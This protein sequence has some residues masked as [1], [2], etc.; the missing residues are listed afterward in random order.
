MLEVTNLSRSYGSFVAVSQVSF[1]IQNGEIVG[2]L[3]HN[4]AG[5]TTIMKMLSGFLEPDQGN[6]V[7]DG[8][9]LAQNSKQVQ[10]LLGYLPEN[11]PV[12]PEMSVAD[13]LDYAADLKGL[14]EDLKTAEVRRVVKA[15]ELAEKINAPIATLSRGFKQ[16]VGVAQALLGKPKVLILDEPTNGLDPTQTEHMRQLIRDIAKSATVILS[17]HIMQEVDA[18]CDR[19]LIV[20]AGKLVLDE[21]LASLKQSSQLELVTTLPYAELQKA[22]ADIAA[23]QAIVDLHE[24]RPGNPLDRRYRLEL[25]AGADSHTTAGLCARAVMTHGGELMALAP[26]IRNLETLFREVS[27]GVDPMFNHTTTRPVS[28]SKEASHAA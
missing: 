3:G 23:V 27:S 11:L 12:Y 26:V 15:T 25:K 24:T 9:N 4:G 18:L 7:F 2:L 13:Y 21:K 19:V 16:R 1:T 10:R 22:L 5:K 20:N 17:T 14:Q 8:L 6:I 28:A